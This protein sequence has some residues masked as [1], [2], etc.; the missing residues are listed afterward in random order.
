MSD[1]GP[2]PAGL[3]LAAATFAA[4]WAATGAVTRHLRRRRILDHP[5]E[6]SSHTVPTPRGGGWGIMAPLLPAIAGIAWH[7]SQAVQGLA[8]VLGAAL[9]IAVSWADDRRSLPAPTR[10][11]VQAVAVAAGLAV[12]PA[13]SL[14]LQG[15]APLWLDRLATGLCW[16][17]FINLFNF[18][19]GIDGLAG[20]EAV[21][22]GLGL[23]LV[24][25]LAGG[26][27]SVWAGLAIAGAASGFLVWNWQPARVFMGDVG[28][29]PLG[30]LLGWALLLTA[31]DGFWA[32]A[33][34]IP[35][36]FLVDATTTLVG[37][38]LAGKRIWQAHREHFYQRAVQAGREH[39]TVVRAVIVANLGL[40]GLAALSVGIGWPALAAGFAVV[41]ALLAVWRRP[42][43][44]A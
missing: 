3:A 35:L 12:L 23:A 32:A 8:V 29:I 26:G 33:L 37:R 18:M 30:Y 19:D 16:L 20:T 4:S 25:L 43:R 13:D 2:L 17:W 24:G 9:L 21:M 31:A 15:L 14:V 5:N 44:A 38:L 42:G 36:Y 40:A 27:I 28:S 11:A 1:L 41:A 6:R 7:S 10:L 22:I 34:L 39:A